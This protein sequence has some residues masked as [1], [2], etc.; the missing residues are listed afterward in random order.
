QLVA[1]VR[2]FAEHIACAS[3]TQSEVVV[4]VIAPGGHV[5]AV[6]DVDSDDLSAF[7]AVDAK[8]L[9]K[10]CKT[11]GERFEREGRFSLAS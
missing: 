7:R 10:L 6:F 2:A 1:D 11:L 4:P 3:S 8:A 5:I 9:E